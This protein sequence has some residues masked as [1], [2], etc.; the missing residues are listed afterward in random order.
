MSIITST[1]PPRS[2]ISA[3][4]HDGIH[5]QTLGIDEDVPL[6]ALDFLAAIKPSVAILPALWAVGTF[7]TPPGGSIR[8][9]LFQHS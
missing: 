7:A 1:P 3:A 8:R 6:L 5:Q 2:W 4:Q 9:P